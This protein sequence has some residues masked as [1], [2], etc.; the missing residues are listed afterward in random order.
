MPIIQC[1]ISIS[2]ERIQRRFFAR[3]NVL[4][5]VTLKL[6]K[7]ILATTIYLSGGGV[8][9][10]IRKNIPMALNDVIE[11]RLLI[12]SVYKEKY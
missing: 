4:T 6:K 10:Y 12:E 1:Q 8:K 7:P 2:Y 9:V 5:E 11:I 3:I